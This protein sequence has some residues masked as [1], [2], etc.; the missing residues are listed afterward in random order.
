MTH[1]RLVALSL[2]TLTLATGAG[3]QTLTLGAG[4]YPTMVR[5]VGPVVT[6]SYLIRHPASPSVRAGHANFEHP[7]F[8]ARAERGVDANTFIVGHPAVPSSPLGTG[9][10]AP[11]VVPVASLPIV[12][13]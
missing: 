6:Q 1:Q 2:L 11:E 7:A 13:R 12:V 9:A 8:S 3:A 4:P 10:T 5:D